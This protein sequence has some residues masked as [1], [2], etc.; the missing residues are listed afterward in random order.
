VV[1]VVVEKVEMIHREE[2]TEQQDQLILAVVAVAVQVTEA[3]EL[4]VVLV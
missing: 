2:E 4:Q 1:Q 3:L